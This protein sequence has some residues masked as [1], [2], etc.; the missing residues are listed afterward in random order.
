MYKHMLAAAN[1]DGKVSVCDTLKVKEQ[2]EITTVQAHNNAIFDL[3]WANYDHK[4]VTSS[5]D[6]TCILWDVGEG[7]VKSIHRF[8]CHAQSVKAVIPRPETDYMYASGGRDGTIKFWDVRSGKHGEFNISEDHVLNNPH[9][10]IG[11]ESKKTKRKETSVKA[12]DSGNQFSITGIAFQDENTI[13]SCSSGD[14]LIKGWDMRRLYTIRL[15]KPLPL[16]ELKCPPEQKWKGFSSLAVSPCR[17]KLYANCVSNCMYCY[18]IA[19]YREEPIKQ[20]EGHTVSSYYIRNAVSPDGRYVASGSTNGVA[21]VWSVDVPEIPLVLLKGHTSE[22][23]C[24]D[25]CQ[26]SGVK[27]VTASDDSTYKVW[28]PCTI[29]KQECDILLGGEAYDADCMYPNLYQ[30]KKIRVSC[31]IK[32]C[33]SYKVFQRKRKAPFGLYKNNDLSPEKSNKRPRLQLTPIKESPTLNLPDLV[34]DGTSPHD[35]H[36]MR[37]PKSHSKDWLT[38]H[39]KSAS[40]EKQKSGLR[41]RSSQKGSPSAKVTLLKYF[42]FGTMNVND[43]KQINESSEREEKE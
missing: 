17:M 8:V 21:Y 4:F 28:R 41:R 29:E 1:E 37:T 10:K 26:S 40:K 36:C 24:V 13:F 16:V 7:R 6:H 42:K 11:N 27:L 14:G 22:V 25:W 18:D 12:D 9:V 19:S 20:F 33:S 30:N 32:D 3:N 5:G 38:R 31:Q 39:R 23:T 15:H 35:H 43:Q 34:K 2:P